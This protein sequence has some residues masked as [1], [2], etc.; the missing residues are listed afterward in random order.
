MSFAEQRKTLFR[1]EILIVFQIYYKWQSCQN[2]SMAVSISVS[3]TELLL[4][5][6]ELWV[7]KLKRKVSIP[8]PDLAHV[9]EAYIRRSPFWMS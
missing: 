9:K 3:E 4:L 8:D 2:V 6:P 1:F 7:S 5:W